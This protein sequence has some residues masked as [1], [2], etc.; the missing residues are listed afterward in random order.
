M[1]LDLI[2]TAF[3]SSNGPRS[4]EIAHTAGEE[5]LYLMEKALMLNTNRVSVRDEIKEI[6]R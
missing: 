4:V 2:E 1:Q 5:D 3:L 6:L